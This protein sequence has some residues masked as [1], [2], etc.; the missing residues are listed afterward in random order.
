MSPDRL[1]AVPGVPDS[2]AVGLPGSFGSPHFREAG[3]LSFPGAAEPLMLP[4]SRAAHRT[5]IAFVIALDF[6]VAAAGISLA[7][8]LRYSWAEVTGS[9]Q[10][11]GGP[12]LLFLS[13]LTWLS[14]LS[15]RGTYRP[16]TLVS[17]T[18][19]LS[20]V[21]SAATL[22]WLGTHLFA[23]WFKLP[24]PFESRLVMGISF[25]V[26]LALFAAS[27]LLLVRPLAALVH[28]RLASGP[29]LFI[30]D[31]ERALES[32]R[33]FES[34]D[35]RR[36]RVA[37]RALSDFSPGRAA[38]VV[39]EQEFGEVF[40]LPEPGQTAEALEVAFAALDAGADVTLMAPEFR[41]LKGKP[42]S[43]SLDQLPTLRLRRLDYGGPEAFFKRMIDVVGSGIGLVLLSPFLAVMALAVKLSSP[44]PV[45]FQQD[46]I[47][48]G[49]APFPMFKFR[50]MREGNDSRA[51][52]AYSRVFIREGAAA[53]IAADGSKIYK[54]T[55]DPRITR[56][57]AIL[58][59]SCAGT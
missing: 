43:D 36:R 59:K 2:E 6:A 28:R 10:S 16:R 20:R 27:R 15:A 23:I 45:I 8:P 21:L 48:R 12:A 53:S 55:S 17:T 46:R 30:G 22:A 38:S 33:E 54:P 41:L 39:R 1:R 37:H 34:S 18:D 13:A 25:P 56:V 50:T 4:A 26:T 14:L 47:G 11:L 24:I 35:H 31:A 7:T 44:G 57:G 42:N 5:F 9:L 58:R 49:G 32:A 51:Y 40:V 29:V 19:Q 52:E 3:P